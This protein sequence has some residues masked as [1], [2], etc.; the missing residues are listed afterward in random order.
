MWYSTTAAPRNHFCICARQKRAEI[1]R[2]FRRPFVECTSHDSEIAPFVK[3]YTNRAEIR[4]LRSES[5]SLHNNLDRHMNVT[6]P[7]PPF[8]AL[9]FG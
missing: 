8:V 3:R 7:R 9:A 1:G 2:S 4:Y 6:D 5:E